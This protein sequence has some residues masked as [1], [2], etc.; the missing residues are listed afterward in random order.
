MFGCRGDTTKVYPRET[1][2]WI[3]LSHQGAEVRA[4]ARMVY[5]G[6]DL[7][8]GVVFTSFEREDERI[9]ECWIAEFASIPN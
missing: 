9:L 6:S 4:L 8:V 1:S 7:G 5:S 3:M 2:V